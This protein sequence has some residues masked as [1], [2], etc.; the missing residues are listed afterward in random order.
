MANRQIV[1]FPKEGYA[2]ETPFSLYLFLICAEGLGSFIRKAHTERTLHGISISQ[3]LPT[4]SHLFFADD[5]SIFARAN[6][7]DAATVNSI[8]QTY[9]HL[10]GQ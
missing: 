9:E 4:L 5:S 1:L 7:S 6:L 3:G 10:S 2:K 8:L